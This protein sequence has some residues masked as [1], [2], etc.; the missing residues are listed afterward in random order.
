MRRLQIRARRE[1]ND[2]EAAAFDVLARTVDR[3]LIE[4]PGTPSQTQLIARFEE[5]LARME[6]YARSG[7]TA[8]LKPTDLLNKLKSVPE[9]TFRSIASVLDPYLASQS[10]RLDSVKDTQDLISQLIQS[11]NDFLGPKQVTLDLLQGLR[12]F[13]HD[14]QLELSSL[15]SGERQLLLLFSRSLALTERGALVLIDEPELSLNADWTRKLLRHLLAPT[16][17]R[18]TQFITATHSIDLVTGFS[19]AVLDLNP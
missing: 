1:S 18:K 12:I 16:L 17:T 11:L 4:V 2:A 5:Q 19:E 6:L 14:R 10:A 3:A 8:N 13:K 7:L 15:S 9:I